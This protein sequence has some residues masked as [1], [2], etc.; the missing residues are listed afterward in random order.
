MNNN[1]SPYASSI[2]TQKYSRG[3]TLSWP[4]LSK[5]VVESVLSAIG[6]R[7]D[8]TRCTELVQL[9][10]DK[11]F[12]PAGCY[13]RAAGRPF[14]QISN[15]FSYRVQDSRQGWAEFMRKAVNSLMT[16]GGVGAE[17]SDLREEGAFIKGSGGFASGPVSVMEMLNECARHIQAGG[18]R[19]AALIA[20]LRWSHP[21]I[22][23]FIHKKN[24]S[25]EVKEMKE[26]DYNF[27]APLDMTNISVRLDQDFF[28]RYESGDS[29][30]H[31]IFN[32]VTYQMCRTG[33]PGFTVDLGNEASWIQ[34]NPCGEATF[35]NDSGVCN[36]GS[37]NLARI[38]S[39]AEME[40]A[41]FLATLFLFAGSIYTD[42]PHEEV[43]TQ[44]GKQRQLGLGILGMHEWFIQ[45][46]YRYGEKSLELDRWMYAYS[47]NLSSLRDIWDKCYSMHSFPVKGRAIAPTGTVSS[48]ADTT[49]GIEPLFCI[50]YKRRYLKGTTWMYQYVVDPVAKRMIDGGIPQD[51]IEDSYLLA[52]DVERRISFQSYL[53]RYVDQAISSTVNL[54]RWGSEFNNEKTL[55]EFRSILMKYLPTLRG[56][57]AYSDGAR[58]G[59]PLQPVGYKTA[60]KYLGQD[61]VEGGTDICELSNRGSCG[62]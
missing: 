47:Q 37:I 41:V 16:G 32:D 46:G 11:K 5:L 57:T 45:R 24:W 60:M 49:S 6:V 8:D 44:I 4:G 10:T 52:Q 36:L 48:L 14:H 62:G 15:C 1:F 40:K 31:A 7:P 61:L 34:R 29:Y 19:R 13:L 58:S 2:Y 55:I 25:L 26:K 56:I 21:D 53:Q 17:Y 59:Q 43:K 54:P 38:S 12:L 27:P 51:N 30:S 50:A 18:S 9:V 35:E 42:T 20:I 39:L 23:K 22:S 3:G 28:D 33:E